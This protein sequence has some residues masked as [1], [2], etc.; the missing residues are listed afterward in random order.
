MGDRSHVKLYSE[1]LAFLEER[2]CSLIEYGSAERGLAAADARSFV[3]LLRA[4]HVPL[5][6]IELW[7]ALGGRL[8]LDIREIWYSSHTDATARYADAERYF[9]RVDARPG[10]VFAIQFS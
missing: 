8:E 6:G 1:L 5:L 2:G 9:N 3:E 10:D 7:R 4:N